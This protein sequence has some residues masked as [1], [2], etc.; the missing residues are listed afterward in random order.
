[1][2]SLHTDFGEEVELAVAVVELVDEVGVAAVVG[3]KSGSFVCS[4]EL[5]LFFHDYCLD[6]WRTCSS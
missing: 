3:G 4:E 5:M 2:V 1:M 6:Y